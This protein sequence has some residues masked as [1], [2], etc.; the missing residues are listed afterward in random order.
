MV[1]GLALLALAGALA[2]C[3]FVVQQ[4]EQRA[5]AE[6][7]NAASELGVAATELGNAAMK[8]D[9][10]LPAGLLNEGKFEIGG[11]PMIEGGSVTGVRMQSDGAGAPAITLD[12]AAPVTPEAVRTYFLDQFRAQGVAAAMAADVLTGT[13]RDGTAFEMRFLPEGTGTTGTIRLDPAAGQ[14]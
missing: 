11:V 1:R 14:P 3:D 7:G 8:V 9:V 6:L 10:K 13:T 2:G 5:A 12:F 4:A